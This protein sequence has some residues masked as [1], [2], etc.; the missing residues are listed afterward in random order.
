[1]LFLKV[2]ERLPLHWRLELNNQSTPNSPEMRFNANAAYNN[3]WQ[4]EHS[5]GVQYS[6]S[7]EDL[8]TGKEWRFYEAPLVVNYSAF[9]RM[10]LSQ[11]ES[12]VDRATIRPNDFGYDEATRRFR[13]P[14][15]TG[16]PELNIYGSRSA[17]DTG[18]QFSPP[19]I[20]YRNDL[21]EATK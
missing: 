20:L 15:A 6:F 7:P 9:Y 19:E 14:P 11:P 12:L 1:S 18:A 8:K 5:A 4:L 16:V 17:I 10:P 2:E 21:R 13:L 3:L